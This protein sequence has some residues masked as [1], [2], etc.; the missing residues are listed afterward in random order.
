[1]KFEILS[2]IE[3]PIDIDFDLQSLR[4]RTIFLMRWRAVNKS[5]SRIPMVT[6]NS[7]F[8]IRHMPHSLD[9]TFEPMCKKLHRDTK[10]FLPH[11]YLL[12]KEVK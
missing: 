4:L 6:T 8:M 1:M 11:F 10:L 3:S 12:K 5:F 7:V 9:K 2:K